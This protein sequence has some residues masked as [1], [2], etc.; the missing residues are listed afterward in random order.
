MLLEA[1]SCT[2]GIIYYTEKPNVLDGRCWVSQLTLSGGKGEQ[3]LLP[4]GRCS[5]TLVPLGPGE[6]AQLGLGRGSRSCQRWG[7]R[8][9]F[10]NAMLPS[11]ARLHNPHMHRHGVPQALQTGSG[12]R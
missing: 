12:S 2:F 6:Q 7:G 5:L 3:Q 9:Q 11:P 1:G 8:V 10:S 4:S